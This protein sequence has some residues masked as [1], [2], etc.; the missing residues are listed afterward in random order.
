MSLGSFDTMFVLRVQGCPWTHTHISDGWLQYVINTKEALMAKG[1]KVNPPLCRFDHYKIPLSSASCK[2]LHLCKLKCYR[3]V[4]DLKWNSTVAYVC[5]SYKLTTWACCKL[6]YGIPAEAA[7]FQNNIALTHT[8][9]PDQNY[10]QYGL[11]VLHGCTLIKPARQGYSTG[12]YYG[13]RLTHRTTWY[14]TNEAA[15]SLVPPALYW[16]WNWRH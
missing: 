11:G 14:K 15:F 3:F 7:Q 1:Q 5:L 16:G 8:S 6:F 9:M 4:T 12:S 13:L 2:T 10:T